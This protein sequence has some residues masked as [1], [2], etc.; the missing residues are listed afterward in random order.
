[1]PDQPEQTDIRSESPGFAEEDYSFVLGSPADG[2][3]VISKV[4]TAAAAGKTAQ[5]ILWYDPAERNSETVGAFIYDSFIEITGN[6]PQEPVRFRGGKTLEVD[7]RDA[8]GLPVEKYRYVFHPSVYGA[9]ETLIAGRDF[10]APEPEKKEMMLSAVWRVV[11]EDSTETIYTLYRD[12]NVTDGKAFGTVPL[13]EQET[14]YFFAVKLAYSSFGTDRMEYT[15][16]K[17]DLSEDEAVLVEAGGSELLLSGE[18]AKEFL[19]LVSDSGDAPGCACVRGFNSDAGDHGEEAV[20]FSIGYKEG[21]G[22]SESRTEYTLYSDGHVALKH[23][24]AGNF[25]PPFGSFEFD[26][27]IAEMNSVSR[28]A[29]DTRAVLGYLSS[30]S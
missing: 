15:D 25:E 9:F 29:F 8:Y 12:G 28:N 16:L 6:E 5:E 26:F 18:Q 14:A 1:M 21:E 22:L 20:K 11:N 7:I 4:D 23:T 17:P 2:A 19:N 30:I 13:T 24:G 3:D 10:S 27:V